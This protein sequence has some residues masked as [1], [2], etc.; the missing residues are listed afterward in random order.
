MQV[1]PDKDDR[2][3]VVCEYDGEK[4]SF[5]PEAIAAMIFEKLKADADVHLG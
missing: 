4:R 1:E 5:Y 2:P 3:M